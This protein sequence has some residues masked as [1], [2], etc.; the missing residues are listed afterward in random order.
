MQADLKIIEVIGGKVPFRRCILHCKN[1]VRSVARKQIFHQTIIHV[2]VVPKRRDDRIG[3]EEGK[4]V[5]MIAGVMARA[6]ANP[7]VG[8]DPHVVVG[9]FSIGESETQV[10]GRR[11]LIVSAEGLDNGAVYRFIRGKAPGKIIVAINACI[12]GDYGKP[13]KA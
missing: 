11:Y 7:A 4:V 10:D 5:A 6:K 2:Q 13:D 9:I 8:A 1:P 12:Y 3:S